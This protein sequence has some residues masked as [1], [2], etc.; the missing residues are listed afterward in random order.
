MFNCVQ[1]GR[2]EGALRVVLCVGIV[3][4]DR[5]RVGSMEGEIL[6]MDGWMDRWI[7]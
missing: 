7:S 4:I 5:M 3:L 2:G 6:R 1:V